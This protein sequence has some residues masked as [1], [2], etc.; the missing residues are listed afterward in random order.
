MAKAK[1]LE[2]K[3]AAKEAKQKAKGGATVPSC[4]APATDKRIVH[5]CTDGTSFLTDLLGSQCD[6]RPIH[7]L[8][9]PRDLKQ[10]YREL[11]DITHSTMFWLTLP[12]DSLADDAFWTNLRKILRY[13]QKGSG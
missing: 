6:V 3:K 9:K 7:E 10:A 8:S 13:V 11:G 4:S 5:F 2:E 12:D 1:A